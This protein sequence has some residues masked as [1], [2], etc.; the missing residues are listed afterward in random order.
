MRRPQEPNPNPNPNPNPDPSPNPSPNS[1]P[2]PNP[3]PD[4]RITLAI[5]TLTLTL[6]LTLR[7]QVTTN[8]Q[9]VYALEM[10]ADTQRFLDAIKGVVSFDVTTTFKPCH[11][12]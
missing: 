11:Y 10:P 12:P 5:L 8:I 9:E 6:T 4:A 7:S 2:N 1:N 3:K